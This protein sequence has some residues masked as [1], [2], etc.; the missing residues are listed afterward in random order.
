MS[1][2]TSSGLLRFRQMRNFSSCSHL[3]LII[4]RYVLR[5]NRRKLLTSGEET[6]AHTRDEEATPAPTGS[7]RL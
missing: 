5:Q 1:I 3:V 4:V 7:R 6:N 2:A